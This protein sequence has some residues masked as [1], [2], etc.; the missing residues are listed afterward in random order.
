MRCDARL[1]PPA[2]I[3]TASD[4]GTPKEQF[5]PSGTAAALSRM[6]NR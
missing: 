2:K 5:V 3:G 6:T 1:T 4:L